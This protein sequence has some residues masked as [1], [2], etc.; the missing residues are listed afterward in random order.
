MFAVVLA[1]AVLAVV[2]LLVLPGGAFAAARVPDTTIKASF[3]SGPPAQPKIN[4]TAAILI[5]ADTGQI[6]F[7]KDAN[8]RLPMASTTKIMTAILVLE[9]LDPTTKV[10]V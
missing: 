1:A 10:K 7:S 4:S 5:D 3:P 9:N 2:L 6:L 8:E